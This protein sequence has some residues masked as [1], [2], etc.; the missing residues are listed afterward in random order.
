MDVILERPMT[1]VV[2][3]IPLSDDT[4][5]ALLGQVNRRR[6]VLDCIVAYERGHWDRAIVMAQSLKIKPTLLP[7]A[8]ADAL[9]WSREIHEG[10]TPKAATGA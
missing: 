1:A 10:L 9:K 5:D 4:R 2:A 3:D 7:K 8:Y 6:R